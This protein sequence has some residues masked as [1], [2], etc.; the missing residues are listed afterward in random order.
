MNYTLFPLAICIS[1]STTESYSDQLDADLF[2][3]CPE[4]VVIE[5][6]QM[7]VNQLLNM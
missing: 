4:E 3:T 1:Q 2:T 5:M 6:L 7:K